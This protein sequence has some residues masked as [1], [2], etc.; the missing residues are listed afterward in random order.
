MT[1]I[2][3]PILSISHL[4]KKKRV[5]Q[6]PLT[7][8]EHLKVCDL[9]CQT[10]D[11]KSKSKPFSVPT[12]RRKKTPIILLTYNYRYFIPVKSFGFYV[13][14]FLP[15]QLGKKAQNYKPNSVDLRVDKDVS[16]KT[17]CDKTSFTHFLQVEVCLS[18]N[19]F[20]SY[21]TKVSEKSY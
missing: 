11:T 6:K 16:Q 4:Q 20:L 5:S 1:R 2:R 17:L 13:L 21:N 8:S 10:K 19:F 15:V 3:C 7:P 9:L 14:L 18:V 12:S